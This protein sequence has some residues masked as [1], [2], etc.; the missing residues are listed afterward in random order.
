MHNYVCYMLLANI[1]T[2]FAND[3][4]FI[5]TF[6]TLSQLQIYSMW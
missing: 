6:A 4:A 3:I 2:E 5:K 1:T